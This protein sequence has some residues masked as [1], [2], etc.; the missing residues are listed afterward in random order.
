MRLLIDGRFLSKSSALFRNE[1]LFQRLRLLGEVD[2]LC[3]SFRDW[4]V[5]EAFIL[6]KWHVLP[7]SSIG[8]IQRVTLR[9]WHDSA[10]LARLA[11][12]VFRL[13]ELLDRFCLLEVVL[14]DL[15]L[16]FDAL[17][18]YFADWL[19][20]LIHFVV[21]EAH[22][23]VPRSSALHHWTVL[24]LAKRSILSFRFDWILKLSHSFGWEICCITHICKE[25]IF[26]KFKQ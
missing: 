19:E 23:W 14:F 3:Q 11:Q 21:G 22:D 16:H 10:P 4:A 7:I 13:W 26:I 12:M 20:S 1:Q 2:I 9:L 18:I 6:L 17:S 5:I 8:I 15:F 24:G 25:L